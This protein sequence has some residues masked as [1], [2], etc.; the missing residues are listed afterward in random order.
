MPTTQKSIRLPSASRGT[1]KRASWSA[2][3]A[4]EGELERRLGELG[5]RP[6]DVGD[7]GAFLDV[8]HG[9]PL[10]RQ[11]ARDPQRRGEA[12]RRLPAGDRSARAIVV[13]SGRPA[14]TRRELAGVA[15]ADALHEAAVRSA[16]NVTD[17]GAAMKSGRYAR[18]RQRGNPS[19]R[20][21]LCARLTRPARDV[22][23][24]PAVPAVFAGGRVDRISDALPAGATLSSC[25]RIRLPVR[26]VSPLA[27][28]RRRGASPACAG[29]R[30]PCSGSCSWLWATL[31]VGWLSLHWLILPHIEEW[32]PA[33]E[34]RAGR[35]L[36]APVRIGAIAARSSGWVPAIELRDVRI[37]DAEQRVALTLPRVFAALSPRSLL[38]LEPR[39]EQ[40]LI[41]GPSLDVR[42]DKSGR[43]RVAG[44]DFAAAAGSRGRRPRRRLVLQP[45]R[46]RDPR[47]RPALD[48]R[49]TR[50]AAAGPRR[51]RAGDSQRPARARRPPRRDAAGRLGRALQPARPLHPA[52]LRQERRL[53][54]VERQRLRRPAARRPER[55]APP[56]QRCRSS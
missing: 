13:R 56:R 32:R 5:H 29:P 47:R 51:R 38:A 34:A 14:G 3:V 17:R 31:F 18:R 37:L 46:V 19:M 25:L 27:A 40:L 26:P 53:A 33:I 12:V 44:L 7:A 30:A 21:R 16:R 48:R 15:A 54:P 52:A 50:C 49:R 4:R 36:G 43:I 28:P 2:R 42:R 1:P 8:E 23:A 35:M 20:S 39:F 6:G 10:E 24:V 11:L 9:E 41:D 45:A 55:A 22:D